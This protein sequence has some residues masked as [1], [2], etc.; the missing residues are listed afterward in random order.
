[1]DLLENPE[2]LV[3]LVL[4]GRPDHR[5]IT[6]CPDRKVIREQMDKMESEARQDVMD[7]PVKQDLPGIP[8]TLVN[9]GPRVGRDHL[10]LTALRVRWVQQVQRA[11][12]V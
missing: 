1:M 8:E 2:S 3:A 12:L 6:A 4:M 7:F 10:A 5:A 11:K 9:Q